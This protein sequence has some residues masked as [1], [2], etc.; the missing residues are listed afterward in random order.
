MWVGAGS[1]LVDDV[2]ELV[3]LLADRQLGAD[4]LDED[5]RELMLEVLRQDARLSLSYVH[6]GD[7]HIPCP[8]EAWGGERD[9]TVS[10]DQLDGWGTYTAGS[11]CRRQFAGDHHF[12]HAQL[13][14]ILPM[15][16][17]MATDTSP[18]NAR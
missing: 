13:D 6:R 10:A 2:D 1:G 17:A 12:T 5:S 7:P 4:E 15:L 11:F 18:A 16:R 3:R 14:L 9:G 8:I